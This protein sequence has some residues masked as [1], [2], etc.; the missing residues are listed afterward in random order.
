MR[1]RYWWGWISGRQKYNMKQPGA[2][3]KAK[4][5][6]GIN[7]VAEFSLYL[8]ISGA[9]PNSIRAVKNIKVLCEE[10]LKGRYTLEIIDVHQQVE[11]TSSEQ[12]VALPLL[13][14][15][16][17]SPIKRLI[18]DMSQKEK[19]LKGLGLHV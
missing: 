12:V 10:Y 13:I 7:E 2:L 4:S 15:K 19:V 11:M 14:K 9:S 16:T 8:F 18:G 17:P 1:K 6:T 5:E 3:K